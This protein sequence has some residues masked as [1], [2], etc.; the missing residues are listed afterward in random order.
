MDEKLSK[1]FEEMMAR[2]YT[3][4][5]VVLEYLY[6]H[7]QKLEESSKTLAMLD[8]DKEPESGD[9]GEIWNEIRAMEENN[10]T[11][12]KELQVLIRQV[13]EIATRAALDASGN[14]E[15]ALRMMKEFKKRNG[16]I[17]EA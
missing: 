9:K 11:A 1:E 15:P 17:P 12:K 10:R 3:Q 8:L 16:H 13:E 4:P 5:E 7:M 2:V 14:P 6:N